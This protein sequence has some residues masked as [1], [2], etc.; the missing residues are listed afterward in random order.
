M[1]IKKRAKIE[2]E[3]MAEKTI[4]SLERFNI[5]VKAGKSTNQRLMKEA[6]ASVDIEYPK[7]DIYGFAS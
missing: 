5:Q 1:K 7:E 3:K 6:V 2:I 4:D